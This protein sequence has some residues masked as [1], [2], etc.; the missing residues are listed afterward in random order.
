MTQQGTHLED[1]FISY[2]STD[3]QKVEAVVA[4]LREANL[5]VWYAPADIKAGESFPQEIEKGLRLCQC[6]VVF[7]SRDALNSYWVKQEWTARLIQM[8]EDRTLG[9]LPVLLGDINPQDIPLLLQGKKF[10]DFREV[11]FDEPGDLQLNVDKLI[12]NLQGKLPPAGHQV[13][14]VPIIVYAMKQSEAEA[15]FQESVFR[16]PQSSQDDFERFKKLKESLQKCDLS[17]MEARYGS[18]REDWLPT[19]S[20]QVSIRYVVQ[21]IVDRINNEESSKVVLKNRSI[22]P[23]FFSS[24]FFS[25]DPDWQTKTRR[26]FNKRGGGGL[27][28]IDT[29]SLFH[30]VLR[31]RLQDSGLCGNTQV[32]MVAISPSSPF[33]L[34]LNATIQTEAKERLAGAFDRFEDDL[35]LACEFGVGDPHQLKRW[36]FAVIP[37]LARRFQD[38][39]PDPQKQEEVRKRLGKKTKQSNF[40]ELIY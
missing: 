32:S 22:T 18:T 21:S 7:L 31:K 20:M 26:I 25:D 37:S 28:I 36:L 16:D 4:R 5:S 8:A 24:D 19:F 27:L 17:N 30:P 33:A 38:K 3:K 6:V 2:T 11:N 13:L 10:F 23:Q 1:V 29:P 14:G 12:Q 9:L 35:E 15:L 40:E 34:E 39:D